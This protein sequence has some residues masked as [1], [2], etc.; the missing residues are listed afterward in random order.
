MKE[1]QGLFP[2]SLIFHVSPA[3][4]MTSLVWEFANRLEAVYALNIKS[5]RF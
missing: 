3:N 4:F 5:T 1:I 2:L